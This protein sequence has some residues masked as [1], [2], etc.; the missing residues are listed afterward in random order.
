MAPRFGVR[1]RDRRPL[2]IALGILTGLGVCLPPRALASDPAPLASTAVPAP[3][4]ATGGQIPSGPVPDLPQL[5]DAAA[6][7]PSLEQPV[8]LVLRLGRRRVFVYEGDRE[9]ASYPVAIGTRNTPT[10]TGEFR[11]FQMIRDPIWQ[12]PWTGRIT[13]P[14]PNSALGLRW[15][16]FAEMPNGIIGFHGTPTV[17]SIGQAASNGCVRMFNHDVVELFERVQMGTIVRVVP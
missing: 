8:H 11:V 7:L 1:R 13:E 5:A 15:I 2:A 9:V 16:G 4:V 12:S 3:S 14:G 17:N 6:Y 10:P